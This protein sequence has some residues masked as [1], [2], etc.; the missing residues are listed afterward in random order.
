[1]IHFALIILLAGTLLP[2]AGAGE[3]DPPVPSATPASPLP[4]TDGEQPATLPWLEEVRAQREAW[5]ARR[6]AVKEAANAQHRQVAPWSAARHEALDRAAE[7]RRD[8]LKNQAEQR[9]QAAEQQHDAHRQ[10]LER[11]L[12]ERNRP[13]P[14]YHPY[15]WNNLWYYRGY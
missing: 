1:M 8:A 14:P 6:R 11:L 10:E 15:G 9:R 5:E 12:W 4:D 7:A 13:W 2:L 3:P